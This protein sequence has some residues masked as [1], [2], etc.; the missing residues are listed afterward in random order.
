MQSPQHPS[1]DQFQEPVSAVSLQVGS[2]APQRQREVSGPRKDGPSVRLA[3][4]SSSVSFRSPTAL[5][6]SIVVVLLSSH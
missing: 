4:G 3:R 2:Q 6:R 1:W 5:L